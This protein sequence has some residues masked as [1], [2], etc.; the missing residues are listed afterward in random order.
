M[1]VNVITI[2]GVKH[3]RGEEKHEEKQK[4]SSEESLQIMGWHHYDDGLSTFQASGE[5]GR[6]LH[7][8]IQ[9]IRPVEKTPASTGGEMNRLNEYLIVE[10][11]FDF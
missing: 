10:H 9:F 2:R 1:I 7:L 5:K 4:A 6:A 11:A 3:K 8:Q